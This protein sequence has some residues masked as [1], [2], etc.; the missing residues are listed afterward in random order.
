[1]GIDRNRARL[2]FILCILALLPVLHALLTSSSSSA[3]VLGRWSMPVAGLI[4]A[5]LLV[6]ALL[7]TAAA[8]NSLLEK[9]AGFFVRLPGAAAAALLIFMPLMFFLIWFL[10]RFPLLQRPGFT[11]GV[12][13]LSAVPGLLAILCRQGSELRKTL[14]GTLT[15]LLSLIITLAAAEVVLRLVMP[16]SAFDPRFGLRPYQRTE[17][18]VRLPGIEPGGVLTTN[19]WGLRG[20]EP[21][22]DWDEYLTIVTVGGSTTANYYLDDSRTWSHVLQEELRR[23]EPRVWVGNGG[24]PAQSS[25]LHALFVR[26]VLSSIQPDI[27]LFLVGVNDMGSFL[28]GSAGEKTYLENLGLRMWLFQHSM[29][30]QLLYKFKATFIEG[31]PVITGTVDPYFRE[32]PMT[33]EEPPLPADLHDLLE[34]P[35]YY[36]ERIGRIISECRRL[37]IV[38]VFMTQ[39]LLYEDTEHW[40]GIRECGM[41][42]DG[43]DRPL[44]AAS[45]WLMLETLNSDLIEVCREEGVAVFD[46]ADVVPHSREYFYDSMHM[47]EKGA[48]LV[49]VSASGFLSGYLQEEGML[50]VQ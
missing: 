39:P 27:A 33:E 23:I 25:A 11:A 26:D 40:R 12:M 4:A 34:N 16:K 29:V 17:L 14:A 45:Y 13:V 50:P 24:V 2:I 44:S 7:V 6:L 42:H 28:R 38:P 19:R 15:M 18:Q 37:E 21:P 43:I 47:T 20:E 46:L 9:T 32:V 35:D 41:W 8:K 31:A 1:M 48:E 3:T 36:R 5:C 22:E 49:G 30:L 10:Y